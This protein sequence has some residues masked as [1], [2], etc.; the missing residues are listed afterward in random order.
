MNAQ[1]DKLNG[2]ILEN[3]K[4]LIAESHQGQE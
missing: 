2:Y 1:Q 4:A 3:G